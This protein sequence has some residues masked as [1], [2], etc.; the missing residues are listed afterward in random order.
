MFYLY[1]KMKKSDQEEYLELYNQFE[2]DPKK[3]NSLWNL[4]L[5]TAQRQRLYIRGR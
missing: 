1:S 3:D 2:N 4:V 5:G